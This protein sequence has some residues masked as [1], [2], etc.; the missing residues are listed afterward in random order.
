MRWL[1]NAVLLLL[2]GTSAAGAAAQTLPRIH[3]GDGVKALISTLEAQPAKGPFETTSEWQARMRAATA[4]GDGVVGI[5]V[6]A[7]LN[8]GQKYDADAELLTSMP[9]R[10]Y[11]TVSSGSELR[12][13]GTFVGTNSYGATA[14]VSRKSMDRWGL[15]LTMPAGCKAYD[16]P[17]F[18]LARSEAARVFPTLQVVL[19]GR[20][21]EPFIQVEPSRV[22]ATVRSPFEVMV[23]SRSLVLQVEAVTV[24]HSAGGRQ[25]V[26][27]T[28]ELGVR[29]GQQPSMKAQLG[30]AC[31][32]TR[33]LGA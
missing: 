27:Y 7:D 24:L 10:E 11:L 25:E 16:A 26:L 33:R 2:A 14:T 1:R 12:D 19:V 6:A 31:D 4:N 29:G 32:M 22:S 20:F 18:K 8:P 30:L 28:D 17:P 5:A 23:T 13:E 21:K 15:R 9:L 3:L